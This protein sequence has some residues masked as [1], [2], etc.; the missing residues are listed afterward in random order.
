MWG[1]EHKSPEWLA[2]SDAF[3][4]YHLK[5]VIPSGSYAIGRNRII[6]KR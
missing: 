5:V 4:A 3:L 2:T 1:A 6:I